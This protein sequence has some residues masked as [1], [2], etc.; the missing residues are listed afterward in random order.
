MLSR[1]P[2][3]ELTTAA[4]AIATIVAATAAAAAAELEGSISRLQMGAITAS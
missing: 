1:S 2:Q 3:K 4:T